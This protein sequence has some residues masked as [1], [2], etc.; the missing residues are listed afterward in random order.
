MLMGFNSKRTVIGSIPESET[1]LYVGL[2]NGV[3]YLDKLVKQINQFGHN[4]VPVVFVDNCS[5]DQTWSLLQEKVH[6]LNRNYLLVRNP[7]NIG[8]LGS[9]LTNLD[10]VKSPWITAIHQDD[11]YRDNHLS[12]HLREIKQAGQNIGVIA[13]DMGVA[14]NGSERGLI[15]RAN[16]DYDTQD[17]VSCFLGSLKSHLTPNP[18]SSY[19]IEFLSN[20]SSPFYNTAFSDT[21]HELISY[22]DWDFIWSPEITIDYF[23]NP[24]S[25][26]KTVDGVGREM[27][28]VNSMCRVFT[29]NTFEY[30]AGLVE[31]RDRDRFTEELIHSIQTRFTEPL[32]GVLVVNQALEKLLD[33][34]GPQTYLLMPINSIK[35]SLGLSGIEA[36]LRS[37]LLFLGESPLNFA[38][39]APSFKSQKMGKL[40]I[41]AFRKISN[42]LGFIGIHRTKKLWRYALKATRP[43]GVLAQFRNS[44]LGITERRDH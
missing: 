10:L 31:K 4:D 44:N 3:E 34:W 26:S 16:W 32:F 40:R 24:I 42:F 28:I 35:G 6:A 21:E 22:L 29:S 20:Y 23:D 17:K 14:I 12:V 37:S 19:R 15:P 7:A 11:F 2:F 8:A 27:A 43:F 9:L 36:T 41:L 33:L 5:S 38:P 25:E 18:A 1:S 39:I 13:T 30:I